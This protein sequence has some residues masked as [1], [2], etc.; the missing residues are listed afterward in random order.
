MSELQLSRQERERREA[1]VRSKD[2]G[3]VGEFVAWIP[4][5]IGV[6]VVMAALMFGM[7]AI[8]AT[9]I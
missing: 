8:E 5:A 4:M 3:W 7:Y 2:D 9:G 1:E 6:A